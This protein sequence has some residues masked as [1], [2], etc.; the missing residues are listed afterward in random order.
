MPGTDDYGGKVEHDPREVAVAAGKIAVIWTV[1]L[2]VV[3][4]AG[5]VW[6]QDWKLLGT[7]LQ[8]LVPGW[9]A[10]A[11]PVLAHAGVTVVRRRVG[12]GG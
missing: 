1:T 10:L 12:N 9:A 11:G 4:V 6:T 2:A 5:S 3:G 8:F 7:V